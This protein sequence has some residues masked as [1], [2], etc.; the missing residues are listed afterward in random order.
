MSSTYSFTISPE[1][2]T[3][4]NEWLSKIPEI[5]GLIKFIIVREYGEEGTHEH[6]HSTL[7]FD[8]DV[9][10]Q[11]LFPRLKKVFGFIPKKPL[12]KVKPLR[13]Q[14][15]LENWT[16]YLFLEEGSIVEEEYGYFPGEVE[17]L[18]L[19]GQANDI[20]NKSSNNLSYRFLEKAIDWTKIKDREELFQKMFE[21]KRKGYDCTNVATNPRKLANW[22]YFTKNA[23]N[24]K[25]NEYA[26]FTYKIFHPE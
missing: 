22:F 19:Q 2:S 9:S 14:V 15:D 20:L 4:L 18:R 11:V 8:S 3:H 23:Y 17:S 21:L 6:L 16:N 26:D 5:K 25:S 10:L 7:H 12:V 1:T 13:T 24:P